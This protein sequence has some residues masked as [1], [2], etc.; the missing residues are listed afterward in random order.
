MAIKDDTFPVQGAADPA[1]P[2]EPAAG[3]AQDTKLQSLGFGR[4]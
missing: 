1:L 2:V 3:S 4:G